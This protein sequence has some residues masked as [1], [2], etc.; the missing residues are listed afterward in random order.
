MAWDR[1]CMLMILKSAAHA[2]LPKSGRFRRR[3]R[4]IAW[5]RD[6]ASWMKLN[7]LQLNSSRLKSCGVR[8]T[9]RRQ[10]L[11][12]TYVGVISRRRDGWSGDVHPWSWH[13]YRR[14]PQHENSR[15]A[16]RVVL[17]C[18]ILRQLRQY[19]RL[20]PPATFQTLVV[21]LVLS[22]LDYGNA[23]LIGLPTYLVLQSVL[24][25]SARM[26]FQLRRSD[27]ITDALP[28]LHWRASRSPSSSRLPCWRR[29]YKVLHGT[30]PAPRY[31]G[32]LVC[33]SDLPGRRRL[34]SASTD[35]LVVPPFKL[36]L[37]LAVLIDWLA[38]YS[39]S[40]QDTMLLLLEH[41]TVC[42][43]MWHCHKHCPLFVQDWKRICFAYLILTLFL[44]LVILSSPYSGFEVALLVRPLKKILIDCKLNNTRK[45]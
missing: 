2:I 38:F 36:Y 23:V 34:R 5:E 41:G 32:P 13:L 1:I 18:S 44:S 4:Q 21:A 8:A 22:R 37:L 16:N 30:A 28:S 39:T 6:V 33:V 25:A 15:L 10:H 42:R 35:R 31:L 40:T 12:P 7:R 20:I 29:L 9:S 3:S 19:R 17:F 14:R 43:R 11:L 45:W 24:N 27:H 26:I